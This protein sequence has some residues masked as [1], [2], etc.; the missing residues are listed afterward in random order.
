MVAALLF[1]GSVSMFILSAVTLGVTTPPDPPRADGTRLWW[2]KGGMRVTEV[3]AAFSIVVPPLLLLVSLT[4]SPVMTALWLGCLSVLSAISVRT[5]PKHLFV[6][7]IIPLY[8]MS[9]TFVLL[10]PLSPFLKALTVA[11]AIALT[12]A[13]V[14]ICMSVCLHRYAAHAAFHCGPHTSVLLGVLGCLA[15]QGGPLWW[16]SQHRCHHKFSDQ[17]RDPHSPAQHGLLEAF[18]FFDRVHLLS[19]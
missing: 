9:S 10:L 7:V 8:F 13:R 12:I 5:C 3:G 6:R 16:A 18:C 14:G 15:N 2:Q 19:T 11:A 17:P 1:L 4:R